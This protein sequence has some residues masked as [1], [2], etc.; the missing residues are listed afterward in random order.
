MAF[1]ELEIARYKKEV[2][3]YVEGK[4]PAIHIRKELDIGFRVKGQSVEIFEIRPRWE[5]STEILE[6]PVAKATYVKTQKTWKVFWQRA[7]LRWNGYKPVLTVATITEFLTL[8]EADE[9]ACF[10]G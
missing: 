2:G 1:S 3:A 6:H 10:W 7:D 8:V 9:Y 4:R 5:D